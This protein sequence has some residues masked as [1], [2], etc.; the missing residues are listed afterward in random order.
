MYNNK[1]RYNIYNLCRDYKKLS[2][3]LIFS[4]Y[5]KLKYWKMI[6]EEVKLHKCSK[7]LLSI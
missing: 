7:I 3:Y 1:L 6:K 4:K 5:L 2:I